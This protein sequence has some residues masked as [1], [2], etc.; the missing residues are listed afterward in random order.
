MKFL[1]DPDN[2]NLVDYKHPVVMPKIAGARK[3][4]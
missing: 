1:N 4:K 3:G 2:S